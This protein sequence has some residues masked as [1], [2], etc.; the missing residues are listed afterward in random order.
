M[1]NLRRKSHAK[2]LAE[3]RTLYSVDAN[4]RTI[5]SPH[6]VT[7]IWLVDTLLPFRAWASPTDT[8]QLP[9]RGDAV[10]T[11]VPTGRSRVTAVSRIVDASFSLRTLDVCNAAAEILSPDHRSGGAPVKI[12]TDAAAVGTVARVAIIA[13]ILDAGLTIRFRRR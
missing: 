3:F 10:S 13:G 4:P 8:A 2:S 11:T 12:D 7:I 9:S 5:R 6:R 1:Q